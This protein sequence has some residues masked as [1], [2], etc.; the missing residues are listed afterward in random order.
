MA[1]DQKYL[2]KP[3]I[4]KVL[5][6]GLQDNFTDELIIAYIL[7]TLISLESIMIWNSC[8]TER[9]IEMLSR[10]FGSKPFNLSFNFC[11]MGSKTS[12]FLRKFNLEN[13]NYLEINSESISNKQLTSVFKGKLSSLKLLVL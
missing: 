1:P 13:L 4:Y 12:K 2:L 3:N 7:K 10:Y 11:G 6:S 9:V 8:I 5:I